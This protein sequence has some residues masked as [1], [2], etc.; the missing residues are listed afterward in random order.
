MAIFRVE[1][2]RNYT[3]MANYHLKDN[4]ITLKAKGLMSVMLSLPEGWDYTLAGLAFISKEGVSAIRAA[5]NELEE[6]GYLVR[7][8]LR[9]EYGQLGDTEYTIYE[10]PRKNGETGIENPEEV[11]D[12][13]TE[14]MCGF[15]TL[16]NPTLENPI[17][18]KPTLDNPILEKPTL[19]NRTQLNTDRPNT[20]KE[21]KDKK[22]THSSN[23]YPSNIHPSIKEPADTVV[24]VPTGLDGV[25]RRLNTA[26]LTDWVKENISYDDLCQQHNRETMD[27]VVSLIVEIL[28]TKCEYFTISG[29]QV[30]ADLV[31]ERYRKI[32]YWDIEYVFECLG[33]SRSRIHNIRQYWFATLFNAPA[34]RSNYYDA[35]V[36]HDY[37]FG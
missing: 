11:A 5:V 9:N 6:A 27:N 14:P 24:T 35:E 10:E 25:Q 19:E 30:P 22:N 3:V 37:C 34:S 21:K 18:E 2:N 26:E 29:K 8:R 36:R 12:T 33:K 16:D 20:K 13:A 23:P 7:R 1:K 32:T 28:S 17:L 15:P 31:Y 4:T